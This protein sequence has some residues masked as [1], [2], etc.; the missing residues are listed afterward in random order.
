MHPEA[1]EF[2]DFVYSHLPDYY[3]RCKV[4]DVGGGDINGN[5]RMYFGQDCEY[6]A[7][8]VAPAPNVSIVCKTSDLT[9]PD[10]TFDVII[11]SECFEHDMWYAESLR[12]IVR[13]LKPGGLFVFTC[14]STGRGEHGTRRAHPN[15]SFTQSQADEAWK[16]YYKNLTPE[17]VQAVVPCED[18]FATHAFFCNTLSHDLYFYGI[19]RSA[20]NNNQYTTSPSPAAQAVPR[21]PDFSVNRPHVSR[22]GGG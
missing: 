18:E 3:V 19:K 10:G 7:N 22:C 1:R 9:F 8:D 16:D 15:C 6:D 21:L 11:S 20:T 2:L 13:M 4:L 14:A 17:D 5:N 12:N